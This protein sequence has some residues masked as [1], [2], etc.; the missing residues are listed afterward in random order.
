[1]A[2]DFD[3][4][5]KEHAQLADAILEVKKA[6]V[7][8]GMRNEQVIGR[9]IDELREELKTGLGELKTGLSELKTGNNELKT[10]NEKIYQL[11]VEIRD[12]LKR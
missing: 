6:V 5:N 10:G 1:M 9:K 7:D 3:Y 11:L 4:R 12:V 8:M 2:E